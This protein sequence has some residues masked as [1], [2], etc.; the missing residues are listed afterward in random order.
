MSISR[1][2]LS[3]IVTFGGCFSNTIMNSWPSV[4]KFEQLKGTVK[5]RLPKFIITVNNAYYRIV[6]CGPEHV[7]DSTIDI[8]KL[9]EPV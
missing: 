1:G 2:R 8:W 3:A 5:N 4:E 7:F 9:S 6:K